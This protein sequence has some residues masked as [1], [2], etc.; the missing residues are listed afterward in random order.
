M[1]QDLIKQ[2]TYKTKGGHVQGQGHVQELINQ[3]ANGDKVMYAREAAQGVSD[4]FSVEKRRQHGYA[5][6]AIWTKST[7]NHTF[8][9]KKQDLP[10]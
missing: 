3:D 8:R 6:T 4:E 2:N 5:G 9:V 7:P 1:L 10:K